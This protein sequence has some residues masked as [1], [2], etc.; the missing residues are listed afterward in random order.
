MPYLSEDTYSDEYKVKHAKG[1]IERVD[2]ITNSLAIINRTIPMAIYEPS[3]TFI[4]DRTRKHMNTLETLDEKK[5]FMFE[6]LGI[7]NPNQINDI[8]KLYDSLSDREKRKFIESAIAINNDGCIKTSEGIYLKWEAFNSDFKLRDAIITIYKKYGHII[9]P[10][11]IFMPKPK[12]GRD[13]H[14]GQDCIGYQYILLLKQSG[15]RGFSVRSAGAISDESLPEKSHENKVG[16]L[17]HS[18]TP[19]VCVYYIHNI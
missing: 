15:E 9:T 4:L 11:N 3:I 7:L 1:Q 18:E 6:I 2:L 13:I 14:I 17:W 12:W 19:I 16:K 10:Y 5:N 8:K